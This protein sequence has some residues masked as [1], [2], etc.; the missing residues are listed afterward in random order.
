[1]E[2]DGGRWREIEGDTGRYSPQSDGGP[3]TLPLGLPL[4]LPLTLPLGLPLEAYPYGD[5]YGTLTLPHLHPSPFS[6]PSPSP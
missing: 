3:L 6:S 1:M 2:G 5:L 4:G